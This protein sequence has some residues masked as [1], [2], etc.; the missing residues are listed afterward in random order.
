M[1]AAASGHPESLGAFRLA[2]SLLSSRM[3]AHVQ[4]RLNDRVT[5]ILRQAQA[6]A[7]DPEG[8]EGELIPEAIHLA[9]AMQ[10][11]KE[12]RGFL[13]KVENVASIQPSDAQRLLRQL[14][15]RAAA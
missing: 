6:L 11:Q 9:V 15:H 7:S 13:D 10:R 12:I 8:F 1:L 4:G 14:D 3:E 5:A 2:L